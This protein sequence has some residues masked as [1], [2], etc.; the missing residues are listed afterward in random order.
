MQTSE[1]RKAW[2]KLNRAK[3]TEYSKKWRQSESGKRHELAR[4]LSRKYDM[5]IEDKQKMWDEQ[6]GLC[7]VC[8]R[9]LPDIFNRDCQ[10]EHDHAT[11]KVRSL[12]HWY[13]NMVVGVMEKHSVPL[14]GVIVYL[15]VMR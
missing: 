10:V 3:M 1:Q 9:P 5:T 7:A 15:K 4:H 6:K 14:E 2:L 13:C 11:N 8:L 12:A